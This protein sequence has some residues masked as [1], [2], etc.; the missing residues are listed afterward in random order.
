MPTTYPG[1]QM[2]FRQ[3]A[4]HP[5]QVDRRCLSRWA[6]PMT[7]AQ[8]DPIRPLSLLDMALVWDWN[9]LVRV[10]PRSRGVHDFP[11]IELAW[12]MSSRGGRIATPLPVF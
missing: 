1:Y 2:R 10:S 6:F 12:K 3:V 7:V 4:G 5:V 8:Y 9:E 11:I